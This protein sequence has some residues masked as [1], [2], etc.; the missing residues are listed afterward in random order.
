MSGKLQP[1]QE[2]DEAEEA[3]QPTNNITTRNK[4][5]HVNK[6]TGTDVK[7]TESIVGEVKLLVTKWKEIT[8]EEDN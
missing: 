6:P 3:V 4:D 2:V 7:D 5:V 1:I 8:E